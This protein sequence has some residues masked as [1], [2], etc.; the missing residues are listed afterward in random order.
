M[1]KPLSSDDWTEAQ[2][3][4]ERNRPASIQFAQTAR[5][6]AILANTRRGIALMLNDMDK[7]AVGHMQALAQKEARLED[8][9]KQRG[10]L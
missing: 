8:E 7:Y 4:R 9:L 5:L 1:L 6:Q 10:R 3:R 2:L